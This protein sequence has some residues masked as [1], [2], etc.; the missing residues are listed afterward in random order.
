L[1]LAQE[2]QAVIDGLQA[3]YRLLGASAVVTQRK[4]FDQ[5]VKA[6]PFLPDFAFLVVGEGPATAE[7]R[8]LAKEL[9]VAER[10]VVLG[11]RDNARDF[12]PSFDVYAMP[13]HSE[14]MPLAMLEA[15]YAA[16]PI[17]CSDIS[18]FR[19]LF[20]SDEVE[21]FELNNI[22]EL[23]RA[24]QQAVLNSERL[25]VKVKARSQKDYS[26]TAMARR[27]LDIYRSCITGS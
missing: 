20:E 3:K 24:V 2:D 1:P 10:F 7:L 11:F 17:V 5:V 15:A 14:G 16:K 27:Y 4:G 23:V 21:F 8:L 9:N 19:E 18:V 26:V 12:L 25:A 6:L 13:S 22:V